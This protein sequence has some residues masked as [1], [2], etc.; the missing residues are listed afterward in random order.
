MIGEERPAPGVFT[1][2]AGS[3]SGT[4]PAGGKKVVDRLVGSW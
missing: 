2:S 4:Q 3:S 1:R